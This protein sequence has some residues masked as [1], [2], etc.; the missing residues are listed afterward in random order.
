MK[1]VTEINRLLDQNWLDYYIQPILA[2]KINRSTR[3][4]IWFLSQ[5]KHRLQPFLRLMVLLPEWNASVGKRATHF[6]L[7]LN[8]I[9]RTELPFNYVFMFDLLAVFF[10]IWSQ[11]LLWMSV[12]AKNHWHILPVENNQ[13]TNCNHSSSVI[14]QF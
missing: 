12:I 4:H 9:C 2:S 11:N 13:Q 1:I 10:A 7:D 6:I 5:F 14:T 8:Y 3:D